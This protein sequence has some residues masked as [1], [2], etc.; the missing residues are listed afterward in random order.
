MNHK[1]LHPHILDCLTIFHKE[2]FPL[3]QTQDY[4]IQSL[5]L[6]LFFARIMKEH[7]L[8]IRGLLD[9]SEEPLITTADQFASEFK[10]LL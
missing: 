9:P 5:E 2:D 4:I 7:A 6:H 1:T 8:F 3:N 10:R